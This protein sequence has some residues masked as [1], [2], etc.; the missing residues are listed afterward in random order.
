MNVAFD[1]NT[2]RNDFPILD[3]NVYG[4]PLVYLDNAA[5]TQKPD[6]V[7]QRIVT[8]YENEN[9]NIHRGVHKLGQMATLAYENA[10]N[11]VRDFIG[12]KSSKEIIFTRGTTEAIN[13]VAATYGRKNIGKGDEIMISGMEHHA[14]IV[15]WQFIC[16]EKGAHL[17]VIPITDLGELDLESFKNL[18]SEKTKVVSLNWVSNALGTINPVEEII[19][20][21][22][23]YGAVVLIDAAQAVAHFPVNMA[24]L[25]CDFFAFSGHKIFA[26]MG[27]GVL[28][29]KEEILETMPPYMGGG[30]MI[31]KVTFEKTTY[32]ELPY[33]FEAGTPNVEGVLGLE[34]ALQ[35][36]LRL[37]RVETEIYEDEL[38]NYASRKM[39]E[40]ENVKIIGQAGKKKGVLS[41]N[42][43]NHHPFDVGTII[44][45]LGV[46][47]RTGH[48]CT[49]P[50][51]DRYGIPGTVRASF[52]IYNTYNEIDCLVE[53][54][55][56]ASQMLA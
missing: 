1:V 43:G 8:Y 21:S 32:N 42:I 48:H 18:I 28:Y 13:L 40:I 49:Q 14:N 10:R 7:I 34:S 24:D 31:K 44:D 5:T 27:I 45:H 36:V 50:L 37:D 16:S 30:E 39:A 29:G 15:P 35:Y 19:K 23:S 46:A 52:S 17:K 20:I 33:K 22:H 11:T 41:F 6:V 2:I 51:M 9:C 38:L 26:P 12:A 3:R 53:S 25:G 55:K 54:C 4:R 56:K 47:V